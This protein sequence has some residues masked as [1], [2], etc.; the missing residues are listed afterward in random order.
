MKIII[1][2]LQKLWGFFM[3]NKS[4][5]YSISP[6]HSGTWHNP[7]I[8]DELVDVR[9]I[10]QLEK[11]KDWLLVNVKVLVEDNFKW[12]TGLYDIQ[13]AKQH[14]ITLETDNEEGLVGWGTM[15]LTPKSLSSLS[16]SIVS[17]QTHRPEALF[18]KL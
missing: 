14:E 3:G 6:M 18:K 13:A 8:P 1:T 10:P 5:S 2:M 9:Y 4:L 7:S 11:G 12:V 16:I 17:S 15:W